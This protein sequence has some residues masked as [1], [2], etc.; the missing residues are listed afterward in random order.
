MNSIK[1]I[2]RVYIVYLWYGGLGLI[3]FSVFFFI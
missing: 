2:V 3:S 1:S